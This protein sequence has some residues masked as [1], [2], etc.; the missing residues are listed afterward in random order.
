MEVMVMEQVKEWLSV[1]LRQLVASPNNVRHHS[2][3]QVEELAAL[4]ASQGLLHQLVVTEQP[5]GRGKAR[6]VKFAVAAGERRRRAMLLLVQQGR[7]SATHE[8]PCELV[9]PE[10]ALALSL[11]E[12]SGREAL[13]PADEFEA[14]KAL[15]DQG[16]G[17]E[18][19]AAMF[20][21]SALTVQRRLKLSALS[22][23]L[24]VL[25]RQDGINLDQLMA[26]TLS[27]DHVV[28][29]RAWFDAAPWERT[30]AAL[31]RQLTVGEVATAGNPMVR[32]IGIEAYEAAGGV[33][34]RDLFDHEHSRLLSDPALL[35]QLAV[36]KLEA[37]ADLV[38]EEQWG[39]VEAGIDLEPQALRQF[40]RCPHTMREPTA[41]EQSVLTA[42]AKR[43][44]ELAL[45][46]QV[47]DDAPQWSAEEAEC[48]EVEEQDI[49]ER[50]QA[51]DEAR[52]TWASEVRRHAGAIVTLDRQ[53][54]AEVIR[55]LV[56]PADRQAMA[57]LS[58]GDGGAAGGAGL[59]LAG[60]LGEQG[61]SAAGR[62]G[63]CSERLAKRLAAHRTVALQVML[64]RQVPVALAA[65]THVFVQRVFGDDRR[66]NGSV[67]QVAP[68]MSGHAVQA[69]ADDLPASAAWQ[70]IE[71]AKQVWQGRLPPQPAGW[72]TWLIALPQADVLDLLALCTAMTVN[73]LSGISGVSDAGG[74]SDVGALADAVGLDMADWWQPTAESYLNHVPK[75]QIVQALQ[76]AGAGQADGG[77][78]GMKKDA[79]VAKAASL[80][81]GKRWLPVP[82]RRV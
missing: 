46:S 28:Q 17:I 12:N 45:Q 30:P 53:G 50:R 63:G 3:G 55:G 11:A 34:R 75:A 1:P 70:A 71:A 52:K 73:A 56:R 4:I 59:S 32:F 47:L 27:D 29:E 67:L 79:L 2:A 13:H 43:S 10:R 5:T 26:L 35:R 54:D 7:L 77:L 37:L 9:P 6:T 16:R 82:L 69:V 8:V 19:V 66:L 38:R 22:P 78:A 23:R 33:V 21:V 68:Q 60:G 36:Q 57:A 31:R 81:A 42:L 24:L 41:R 25:Y 62:D 80:L 20:G 65:L 58:G 72:L 48:I 61:A 14:F 51:I 18:D 15:M 44:T 64:S 49:A 76:E 40:G 39:W 74:A